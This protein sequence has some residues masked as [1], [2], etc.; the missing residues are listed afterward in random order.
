MDS[1]TD[2]NMATTSGYMVKEDDPDDRLYRVRVTYTDAQGYDA[3][4][5]VVAIG[6]RKDVDIDDDGLIEVYYLEHLD[7]IRY[8]LRWFRLSQL[9]QRL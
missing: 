5:N 9:M 4:E 6:F 7:A 2:I 1:W 3:T 8:A